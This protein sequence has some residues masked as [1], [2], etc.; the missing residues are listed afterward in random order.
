[1]KIKYLFSAFAGMLLMMSSC[2]QD[3]IMNDLAP[4]KAA[5]GV[6]VRLT[7]AAAVD[8]NAP[9]TRATIAAETTE[10]TI[11]SVVAA[12]FDINDGFYK[13]VDATKVGTDGTYTFS[14]EKDGTYDVYLIA[15][16]N[17][18]LKAALKAIPAGTKANNTTSGLAG[19]V[20][21][22]NCDTQSQ[23]LMIS[24]YP[25]RVMTRIN[26]VQNMGD[27][28]M[29][30]LSARFDIVNKAAGV[31]VTGVTFQKRTVKASMLTRNTMPTTADWFEASK[32]YTMNLVGNATTPTQNTKTIYSYENY[33]AKGSA[34]R[35]VITI[36]YT[37]GGTAKTQEVELNDPASTGVLAIKRNHLYRIVL[38]MATKLNFN[39]EVLD[40][41][42]DA[43]FSQTVLPV[44]GI[45]AIS[46][47]EQQALNRKLMVY[48]LFTDKFVKSIDFTNKTA[49]LFDTPVKGYEFPVNSYYN[50]K[51]L[52]DNGLTKS[53]E[54]AYLTIGGQQYRLPTLGE[55]Q[56]FMP[57]DEQYIEDLNDPVRLWTKPSFGG[58]RMTEDKFSETV[59]MK[60]DANQRPL[61]TSNMTDPT[62]AFSGESQL[63]Y[64]DG[65]VKQII[66]DNSL[67]YYT[68]QDNAANITQYNR[69]VCYG[70]RFKGSS[71]YSAYR[72]EPGI[73]D[74]NTGVYYF[75][76]KIKALPANSNIDIKDIC[77]NNAFWNSDFIEIKL[78]YT[79]YKYSTA[80]IGNPFALYF[81]S[82]TRYSG[83][84]G[85][86]AGTNYNSCYIDKTDGS[87]PVL[88]VKVKK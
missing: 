30:R 24:K 32:T 70:I 14:C 84:L 5:P 6:Y 16:A 22:Q 61:V 27:H 33:S 88:L 31:T 86:T 41:T 57:L 4:E 28:H 87:R 83:T 73:Y 64:K 21:S 40:W 45:D 7:G 50:Y 8:D 75:S 59:Y 29:Q 80:S 26:T 55:L 10:K 52:E 38:S 36:N 23:F 20:A 51:T 18:D 81:Y 46:S 15:N 47:E 49:T 48:D 60:N 42:S 13:T 74:S 34:N 77:N 79:G 37:E 9:A 19:I 25:D 39:V 66:I 85:Y 11:N 54:T 3:D 44:D 17:A 2:S 1:M 56:L 43:A 53:D 67:Q 68:N 12:L 82:S 58:T 69:Y 65:P 35:P 62:V 63:L 76:C 78:P 72:W 71:Q